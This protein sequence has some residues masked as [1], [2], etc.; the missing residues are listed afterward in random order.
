[1]SN[2]LIR[3]ALEVALNGL[4]PALSTNWENVAY[5]PV[6][7]TP[8]QLVNLLMATPVN[9]SVGSAATTLVRQQGYLQVS[10]MY[11][12]L[13]GTAAIEARAELIKATFKRGA[14]FTNSGQ[15]VIIRNTPEITPGVR[16]NDRW[17]VAVKIPFYSN[18]FV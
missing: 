13:D 12:L 10:L 7:G 9:P 17:R 4:S 1:M 2:L 5:T 8:Y 18:E 15:T 14:S 3:R 6:N 16:D 11:H